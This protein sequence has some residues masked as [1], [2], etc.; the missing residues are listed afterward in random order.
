VDAELATVRGASA[1]KTGVIVSSKSSVPMADLAKASK[2]P[3]WYGV[4]ADVKAESAEHMQQAVAAGCKA[5]C[6]T[7]GAYGQADTISRNE[8]SAIDQLRKAVDVPVLIKGVLSPK[9][10]T[11]AIAQ[12]A[13]GIIVSNH[14]R[15]GGAT[16]IDVLPSIVD[17]VGSHATV[18]VDSNF[19][20]GTDILKALI[21]GAS[22]VLVSRPVMWGLATYGADGVQAV[23]EILQSD[24]GRHL[25]A[26]GV[27]NLKGLNR[28]YLKVHRA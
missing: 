28:T 18:L 19:R 12:G 22:G 1:A 10:A 6:F 5:C 3:L 15:A 13:K 26:I 27:S 8:W 17:A 4:Y 7:V 9:D 24:L 11:T 2:S 25:A 20:R 23:I 21:I 16:P 14:G